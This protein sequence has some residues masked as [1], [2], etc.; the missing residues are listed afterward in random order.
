MNVSAA[1]L[2]AGLSGAAWAQIPTVGR[3]PSLPGGP[4]TMLFDGSALS[5]EWKMINPVEDHW[6]MQPKR[7]SILIATQRAACVSAKEGK[8]L[9]VLDRPL[10]ADDFE[11]IVRASAELQTHGNQLAVALWSDD[12]SYFWVTFQGD[13][14]FGNLQRRAYFQKVSQGQVAGTFSQDI[15]GANEIYLRIDREGNEYSGYFATANPGK[16]FDSGK[17]PWIQLGTIPGIHFTGKL[18]LCAVNDEDGA[19]EVGAEFYSVTVRPK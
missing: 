13:N 17:I 15:A 6:T 18:A 12:T 4:D 9:L 3:P 8:N 14:T 10:P 11:V 19:P 16:P 2:C 7:K 1:L 5:K